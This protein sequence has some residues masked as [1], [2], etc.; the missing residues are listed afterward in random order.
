MQCDQCPVEI[1]AGQPV[2][3]R[4]VKEDGE[5]KWIRVCSLE[6][7]QAYEEDQDQVELIGLVWKER[8]CEQTH[9]RIEDVEL[10]MLSA[11]PGKSPT[12]RM[13]LPMVASIMETATSSFSV[14]SFKGS[15]LDWIA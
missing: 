14:A 9:Q 3:E 12:V 5:L 15:P 7:G 4:T 2:F 10:G 13:F 8:V 6:C 1:E 11:P